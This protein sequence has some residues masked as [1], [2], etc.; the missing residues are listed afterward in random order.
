MHAVVNYLTT[1]TSLN[2]YSRYPGDKNTADGVP[3]KAGARLVI[4][5]HGVGQAQGTGNKEAGTEGDTQ[6][7]LPLITGFVGSLTFLSP[8]QQNKNSSVPLGS[9]FNTKMHTKYSVW[10]TVR[11]ECLG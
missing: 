4:S 6:S 3:G 5:Y 11:T 8:C 1:L 9:D 10:H 2:A 7:Y